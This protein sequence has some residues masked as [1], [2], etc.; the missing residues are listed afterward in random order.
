MTLRSVAAKANVSY[1]TVSNVINNKGSV[2][3]ETRARVLAAVKELDFQP[4]FAARALREARSYTINCVFYEHTDGEIIDPYHNLILAAITSEA[5]RARHSVLSSFLTRDESSLEALRD[6]LQQHRY[7][8]AIIVGPNLTPPL[9]D[10]FDTWKVPVVL[11]DYSGAPRGFDQISGDYRS[12]MHQLVQHLVDSGR[13]HLALIIQRD[14]AGTTA[15]ERQQGFLEA[16]HRLGVRAVI[17]DGTWSVASGEHAFQR[18]WAHAER[19]DAVIAANDRMALGCLAASRS[20][21]LQVPEDVAISGFDDFEI[22]HYTVPTL[23]TVHV[24]YPEMVSQAVDKLLDRI[25]KPGRP[26]QHVVLPVHVLP[27]G[28]TSATP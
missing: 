19:P 15:T 11:L 2:S 16:T 24:P 9:L 5:T 1:Q 18:L 10:Y 12:G 13:H 8:G 6:G 28:S 14:H 25:D 23:T 27:R 4:N 7:D 20:L 21:G 17:E 26:A 22:G 3:E